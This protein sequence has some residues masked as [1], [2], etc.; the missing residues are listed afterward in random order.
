[1]KIKSINVALGLFR[2]NLGE[3]ANVESFSYIYLLKKCSKF[4]RELN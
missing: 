1:M 2:I 3:E 4:N